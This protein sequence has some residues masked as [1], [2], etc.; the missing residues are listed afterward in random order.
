LP[1]PSGV[2][3]LRVRDAEEGFD[4]CTRRAGWLRHYAEAPA[5]ARDNHRF[6][7]LDTIEDASQVLA[8]L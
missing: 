2:K 5:A 4:G 7:P 1:S 8:K 6:S 3:Q